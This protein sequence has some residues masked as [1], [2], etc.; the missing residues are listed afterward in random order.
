MHYAAIAS[1][2][3]PL[4]INSSY[5]EY[6]F[7]IIYLDIIMTGPFLIFQSFNDPQLAQEVAERLRQEDIPVEIENTSPALDPVIIG[8]TLDAHVRIKVRQQDFEKAHAILEKDYGAQLDSVEKDYY[9]FQFTD[10]ELFEIIE[11]PDEWGA[12]DYKLAQKIL[13]ERG[14]NVRPEQIAR[15]KH[16]RIKE[17][18]RPEKISKS[19]IFFGYFLAVLLSPCAIFFGLTIVTLKKTLPNGQRIYSYTEADRKHGIKIFAISST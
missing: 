19:W 4:V 13:T 8:S 1:I 14:H 6:L 3:L 16:E 7:Q 9:L 10:K 18:S 12:F 15:I 17:I 11:K 2:H 5:F